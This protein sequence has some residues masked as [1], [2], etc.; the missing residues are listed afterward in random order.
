M[1]TICAGP[2]ASRVQIEQGTHRGDVDEL[3]GLGGVSGPVEHLNGGVGFGWRRPL[4]EYTHSPKPP[5]PAG[6]K[7]SLS[8]AHDLRLSKE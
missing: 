2:A 8:G 7:D 1:P 6:S 3:R 4:I 5:P